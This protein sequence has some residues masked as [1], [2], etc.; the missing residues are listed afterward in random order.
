M[1][2]MK[3]SETLEEK[4]KAAA[5]KPAAVGEDIDL[6]AFISEAEPQSYRAD[7][8]QLPTRAKEQMLGVGVMLDDIRQRAGTYIQTDNTPV[9]TSATQEG[10]PT[11]VFRLTNG[12]KIYE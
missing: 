8:S 4:A 7:A 1:S 9:H 6:G 5:S 3:S 11:T 12:V 2:E 10:N